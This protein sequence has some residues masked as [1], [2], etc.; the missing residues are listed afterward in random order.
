MIFPKDTP[1]TNL[2]LTL[3]DKMNVRP[4]TIAARGKTTYY[5]DN[6]NDVAK[7]SPHL[8]MM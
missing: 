7:A 1:V 4:E 2:H 6:S 5:S 8:D 3:L